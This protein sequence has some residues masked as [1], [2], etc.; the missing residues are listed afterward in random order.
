MAEAERAA[1]GEYTTPR[2]DL[3]ISAPV[4]L[5]RS[6]VQPVVAQFLAAFPEVDVQ[7]SLQDR[8]VNLLE[9]HIDVALR[10]GVLA[11]S[12]L[13]AVRIGEIV[14]VVC[15][16][17]AYLKSRGT[18]NRPMISPHTTASATRRSSP[19]ARGH[20]SATRLNMLCPCDPVSS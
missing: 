11:D 13:I 14:R 2:G 1:S 4:A 8:A 12:G 18:P 19:Q 17:S 3:S 6:Y 9:E 5:G 7:L 20:S 16:S 10:I 15:A